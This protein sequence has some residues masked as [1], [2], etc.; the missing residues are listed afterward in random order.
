MFTEVVLGC[1]PVSLWP[2][3]LLQILSCGA[4]YL[5]SFLFALPPSLTFIGQCSVRFP[6][7]S[8]WSKAKVIP[9]RLCMRFF[10]RKGCTK[11]A[12]SHAK[13]TEKLF[14]KE[15]NHSF[16]LFPGPW[17]PSWFQHV[18]LGWEAQGPLGLLRK[19]GWWRSRTGVHLRVCCVW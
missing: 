17:K 2:A 1:L 5:L 14:L 8:S 9:V 4:D 15:R 12:K 7:T 10:C 11:W 18:F 16:C 6:F 13:Y 3:F 19:Q